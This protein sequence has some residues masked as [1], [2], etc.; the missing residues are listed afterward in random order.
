VDLVPESYVVDSSCACTLFFFPFAIESY[1]ICQKNKNQLKF[2]KLNS[3][4][5]F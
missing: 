1:L 4:G 3:Y 2:I 5:D